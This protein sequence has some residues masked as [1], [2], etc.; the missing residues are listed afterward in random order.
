MATRLQRHQ[1]GLLALLPEDGA[2]V[3]NQGLLFQQAHPRIVMPRSRCITL[4]G[5]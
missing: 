4:R 2:T 5:S 1:E 3:G